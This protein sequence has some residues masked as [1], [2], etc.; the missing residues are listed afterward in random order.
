MQLHHEDSMLHAKETK[1]AKKLIH[2][3]Q[4][5][6][7]E[8]VRSNAFSNVGVKLT[9]SNSAYYKSLKLLKHFIYFSKI[10]FHVIS[11]LF[12]MPTFCMVQARMRNCIY[13]LRL[14][15]FDVYLTECCYVAKVSES[16]F[17]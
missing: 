6:L 17:V 7:D 16:I 12:E 2:L 13:T 14:A 8:T 1:N 10:Y 5:N 11:E 15:T 3:N 9:K 4:R